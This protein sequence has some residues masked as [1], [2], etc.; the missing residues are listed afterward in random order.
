MMKTFTLLN[1]DLPFNQLAAEFLIQ[2]N[3][4]VVDSADAMFIAESVRS[5]LS[6]VLSDDACFATIDGIKLYTANRRVL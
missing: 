4:S 2:W 1:I 6:S 3:D 5:G